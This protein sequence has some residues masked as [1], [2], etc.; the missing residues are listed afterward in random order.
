GQGREGREGSGACQGHV[1]RD[2][3]SREG[4]EVAS[5]PSP[6]GAA[7]HT[8][9]CVRGGSFPSRA[10]RSGRDDIILPC[11]TRPVVRSSLMIGG[12]VSMWLI[13]IV[14][15]W[16]PWLLLGSAGLWLGYRAVRALEQRSASAPEL[17]A[18]RERV[19]MLEDQLTEQGDAIRRLTEG[20]EFTQR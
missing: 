15:G 18:L 11:C 19:Q 5:W 17:A 2:Q 10:P 1:G 16:L 13:A 7:P 4:D 3:G 6:A 12:Y 8:L 20:Q 9:P 14:F